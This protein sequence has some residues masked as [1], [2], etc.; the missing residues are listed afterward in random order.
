MDELWRE[1]R[2]FWLSGPAENARRLDEGCLL[3]LG[4]SRGVA[5][6]ILTR[7]RV[8]STLADLPRWQEVTLTERASIMTDEVGVLAYKVTARRSGAEAYRAYCTT[9]WIRRAADW[10]ILQHQ[11]SPV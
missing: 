4:P 6:T 3:V 11:Q 10:H 5:P 1:E 9:T 2:E 8:I 7:E